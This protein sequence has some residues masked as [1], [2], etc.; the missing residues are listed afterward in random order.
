MLYFAN[1][2]TESI[3]HAMRQSLLGVI[4]TPRQQN[5][6]LPDVQWCADNGCFGKGYPGDRAYLSW[7]D[8]QPY[9]DLCSFATAPDVPGDARATF[10]RSLPFLDQ[11]RASGYPVAYVAQDGMEHFPLIPWDAFDVLFIGGSTDWKLGPYAR[12]ITSMARVNGK[13]VHMGRVNSRKRIHYADSIGCQS[14]DGTYLTYGPD[15]NLPRLLR[16]LD[17]LK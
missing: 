9:K 2:S 4:R 12:W 5:S 11:I 10:L 14:I 6:P 1:P 13:P 8:D 7:L 15:V 17:E 16:W 3:R